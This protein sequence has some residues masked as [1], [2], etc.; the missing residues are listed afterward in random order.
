M[1][2][3]FIAVRLPDEVIGKITRISQFFQSQL[4]EEALKWVETENLH[5]TLRF[6]GE[7]PEATIEQVQ[8][9]LAQVATTQKSFELSVEGLGMYPN[10]KQ[11]RTIWLGVQGVKPLIVL[12]AEL[13]K[14]LGRMG[15]EK[16]SRP[17]DPHLTLAR[18]RDRTSR[19]MA[20][21]IGETLATFKVDSLGVFGVSK[22]HLIESQLTPQGPIYTT[23]FT[24]PLGEV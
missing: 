16:E 13:E 23:R 11:P 18:V 15:I 9:V 8:Q 2:R 10:P 3:I 20:H 24:A 6:L 21:Q 1:P 22:I 14:A 7:I 17:F 19:E 4:P 12:H 5:L